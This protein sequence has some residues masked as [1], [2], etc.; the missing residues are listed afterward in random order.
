[1]APLLANIANSRLLPISNLGAML[2]LQ[3]NCP[4]LAALLQS[5][6]CKGAGLLTFPLPLLAV[7]KWLGE[8]CTL[9]VSSELLND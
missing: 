7:I 8:C 3:T 6:L 5:R 4:L 9:L 1:M 2:T